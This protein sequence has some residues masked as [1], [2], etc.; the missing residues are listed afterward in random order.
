MAYDD[1]Q[2]GNQGDII[3]TFPAATHNGE[4]LPL[5][6]LHVTDII[7]KLL[8]FNLLKRLNKFRERVI[9]QLI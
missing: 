8:I 6:I 5:V 4:Y 1:S 2:A 7:I 3:H 9:V